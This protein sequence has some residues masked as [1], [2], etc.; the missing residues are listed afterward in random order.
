[1]KTLLESFRTYSLDENETLLIEGRKEDAVAKYPE[2]AK[3]REELDGESLLDTL[4]AADPSGNQKYLMG[5][6]RILQRSMENAEQKNGYEPFWGKQW[7]E[8]ADDNLYS[9]WGVSKNIADLLPKYHKLIPS[10]ILTISKPIHH[11]KQLL[12]QHNQRKLDVN[13]RRKKKQN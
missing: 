10:K 11:S 7:P 4:I 8:D 6:A 1:M 13:K 12:I 9:P 3:K 5:A 2:L